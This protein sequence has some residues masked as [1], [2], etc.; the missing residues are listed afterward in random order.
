M[1]NKFAEVMKRNSD[2]ELIKITTAESHKYEAEALN[3]AKEELESR[4]IDD[5]ILRKEVQAV[6]EV[7]EKFK[8][9]ENKV[10]TRGN[11]FLHFVVDTLLF[12][13]FLAV[14]LSMI[15]FPAFLQLLF[16]LFLFVFYYTFF[17]FTFQKT[18]GKFITG[19]MVVTDTGE[20]PTLGDIV[21][22]SACR[23]I[24][25]EGLSFMV[26]KNGYHDTL[27]NTK[28]IKI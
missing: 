22:R 5:D 11:R 23:L 20:K 10:A 26:G 3:A 28:V 13:V 15:R 7:E 17:E 8:Y 24:P 18:I 2:K 19:T 6:Y 1:E 16:N 21:S 25:L 9:V 14:V 4:N 27:S 12:Y